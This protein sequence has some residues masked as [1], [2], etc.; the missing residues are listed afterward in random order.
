MIELTPSLSHP[1][2]AG[3][4]ERIWAAVTA[5]LVYDGALYMVRRAPSLAAFPG[6]EAFPGGKLER[7]D[8]L[9]EPLQAS[10]FSGHDAASIRALVRELREELDFDLID[11]AAAGTIV[12]LDFI[13]SFVTPPVVP[14]RYDTRFYRI[15]LATRPQLQVDG[16]E[17][18]SG[19]WITARDAMARYRGGEILLAPPTLACLQAFE[20]NLACREI[21]AL[22]LAR[23]L[24]PASHGVEHVCGV[25]QIYVAS[26]T[27]PPAEHTNCI[28]FGDAGSPRLAL[29][30]SP[31]SRAEFERISALLKSLQVSHI[32]LTHHHRDHREQ[33]NALARLNGW[34]I[35]LSRDTAQRIERVESPSYFDGVQL[36]HTAEGEI[37]THWLGNPVRVLEV[38]GHDEG[39]LA[40][41]P[42]NA[43]WCIVGDLI[44]GVGTVVISAPEGNMARYFASLERLIALA[45]RVIYPSHG[46]PMGT[47]FRLEEVLKHRR[48]RE[49][50][51]LDLHRAGH[52]IDAI[53]EQLYRDTD[54]RIL[55]YARRNIESHLVKLRDEAH[56]A[57]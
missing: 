50:Q 13:G 1:A 10:I 39:Q 42:D 5:V 21:D 37:V 4:T 22:S 48:L 55:P 2:S 36:Q 25:R 6:Y 27:L 41:M 29:D 46:I 20:A 15:V 28:V 23:P 57:G 16:G 33:V 3:G 40:L 19:D 17:A 43:A 11:A 45:P 9:G 35:I 12:S 14:R 47:V 31:N 32:F 26:S 38:P 44:Q 54:Q 7:E 52:G 34:P 30:P 56:I 24:D 49:R 51:I 18:V 53:L 8:M